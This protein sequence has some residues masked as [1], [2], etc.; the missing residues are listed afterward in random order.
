MKRKNLDK[1]G[2]IKFFG[3]LSPFDQEKNQQNF[4]LEGS[5]R[6]T[7]KFLFIWSIISIFSQ[8][9]GRKE[10]LLLK[11]LFFFEK[12]KFEE[13][14][15]GDIFFKISGIKNFLL[16]HTKS[17]SSLFLSSNSKNPLRKF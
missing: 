14:F 17:G 10:F 12:K 5:L 2:L 3:G 9:R 13:K 15:F 4:S 7:K 11:L 1:E 8:F 16:N 6:I